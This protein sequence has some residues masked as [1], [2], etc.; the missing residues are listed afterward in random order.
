ML[1]TETDGFALPF[2]AV[3]LLLLAAMVGAIV[4]AMKEEKPKVA[5]VTKVEAME[6]VQELVEG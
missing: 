6:E 3:S 4:I 2:E 5:E 1:N